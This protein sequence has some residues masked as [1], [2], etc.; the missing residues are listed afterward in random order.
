MTN[1]LPA[2]GLGIV[3]GM[4]SMMGLAFLS[5]K[6][7]DA[8]GETNPALALLKLPQTALLL[9]VM[10]TGEAIFDKTPF[11]PARTAALPLI[12]RAVCGAFVGAAVSKKYWR[13]GAVVGAIGAIG[14]TYA[15]YTIRKALQDE[16]HIPN[17]VLGFVEDTMAASIAHRI[18]DQA[19]IQ[20]SED[21]QPVIA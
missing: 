1:L 19:V 7:H 17:V 4:R 9:K 16:A 3:S 5:D 15:A 8:T 14:S 10:G 11:I 18:V 12:G 13:E 6:V 2:L 20:P 21:V